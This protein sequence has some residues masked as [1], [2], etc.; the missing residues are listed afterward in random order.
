MAIWYNLLP[1]GTYSLWS[2]VT[3]FPNSVCLDQEKSGNPGGEL[4]GKVVEVTDGDYR[5]LRSSR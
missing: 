3:I 5:H 1:F 2:F 4:S